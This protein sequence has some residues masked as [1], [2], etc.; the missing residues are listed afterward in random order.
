MTSDNVVNRSPTHGSGGNKTRVI[1]IS[2]II[3]AVTL[4]TFL[5]S[6][7]STDLYFSTTSRQVCGNDLSCFKND[8]SYVPYVENLVTLK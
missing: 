1:V 8:F 3:H 6:V 4:L 7:V 5:Y 2:G